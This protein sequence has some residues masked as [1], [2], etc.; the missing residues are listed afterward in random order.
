[1]KKTSYQD[2]VKSVLEATSYETDAALDRLVKEAEKDSGLHD[3]AL[4]VGFR[5]L[6]NAQF[7][8]E[9]QEVR[10]SSQ[11]SNRKGDLPP[12]TLEK[13]RKEREAG[14]Q[15]NRE[16]YQKLYREGEMWLAYS[17][18][19]LKDATKAQLIQDYYHHRKQAMTMVRTSH[20]LKNLADRLPHD[21][22]RV[23]DYLT[24]EEIHSVYEQSGRPEVAT[25]DSLED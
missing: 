5:H 9:N 4:R 16:R 22:A 21:D 13:M 3:Y 10:R 24:S 2:V 14:E 1:M 8:R 11:Q 6:I 20:F 23:S 19:K 7:Q 12:E 18:V 25:A 17:R 15:R